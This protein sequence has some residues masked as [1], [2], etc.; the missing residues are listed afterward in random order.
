MGKAGAIDA[1]LD[2]TLNQG[3]AS[4]I[5]S[6]TA[7]DTQNTLSWPAIPGE[8]LNDIA[9]AFYPK[10][11]AMRRLFINQT[12]RLN[13]GIGPKLSPST[14]FEEPTL[15]TI[16]TLRSLSKNRQ[17]INASQR[18]KV[19]RQ[20]LN[21]SFSMDN[22]MSHIPALLQQEYEMLVSKNAFLKAELERLLQKISDLQTTL[23]S[24]KLVLDKTLSLSD[25][26]ATSQVLANDI[27]NP[28]PINSAKQDEIPKMPE[29]ATN[30]QPTRKT[31]K[32]LDEN[33]TNT[34]NAVA[35]QVKPLTQQPAALT[36]E[37]AQDSNESSDLFKYALLIGFVLLALITLGAYWI[38]RNR[39]RAFSHFKQSVPVMDD[40]MTDYGGQWQDTEQGSEY[41][42]E[43][44]P[45]TSTQN[46]MNT[47]MRKDQAKASSTLEE[48]KLLMTVSRTQDAI[49]H[50]K[51][52][53]ETQPKSSINHWLFLLEIYRKLNAKE[54]FE[55][56]AQSLHRTFNVM[57]PVWYETNA[58]MMDAKII[59][60]QY[61]E[62]FPHIIDKLDAVWPSDLAKVYLE[63]L[64]TDNRDGERAGFSQAVLDDILMLIALLDSRKDFD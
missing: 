30:V 36:Q 45:Q 47:E 7:G 2:K 54:D 28:L 4:S 16:P 6:A 23:S 51:L 43:H 40:T 39:Q 57:T 56:Y 49:D 31:F 61:L 42:V 18:A 62:E 38:R 1:V 13:A 20:K 37:G 33:S 48:A 34:V 58:A 64:I 35:K 21:M 27:A 46:F 32:N 50:L 60:P 19:D 17:A 11:S 59:V 12:L 25:H 55:K 29:A 10:S 44:E 22:A 53:I 52:S 14:I 15:L 41:I 8:N 63:S 9:R 5:S 26:Q 3:N 24:L